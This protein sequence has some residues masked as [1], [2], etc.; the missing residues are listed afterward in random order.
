MNKIHEQNM[1]LYSLEP[2]DGTRYDVVVSS[3]EY[4]RGGTSD[5]IY[6]AVDANG[7]WTGYPFYGMSLWG[8]RDHWLYVSQK[9]GISEYD[10]AMVSIAVAYLQRHPDDPDG[11]CRAMVWCANT[12]FRLRSNI[13]A[14]RYPFF[15]CEWSS[16]F[17]IFLGDQFGKSHWLSDGVDML[18]HKNGNAISVGTKKFYKELQ[19]FVN[20]D[21][22]GLMEAYFPDEV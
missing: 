22:P 14:K 9:L 3:G 8:Q 20:Q 1:K 4:M 6:I 15:I 2:G 18:F 16:G 7:R 11:A 5:H 17:E 12:E 10:A 13:V 21:H 19:S